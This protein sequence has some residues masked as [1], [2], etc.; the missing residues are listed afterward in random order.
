MS[1]IFH[2]STNTIAR[3][4]IFGAVFVL[5][6]LLFLVAQIHR[7]PWNTD[8]GVAREQPVQFSHEHHVG[9]NGIDCRYCHTSVEDSQLR[10]HPADQDLH[11]LPLARCSP[12]SP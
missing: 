5:T 9:G 11:E 3:A 8:A 12:N 1:Q 4:S 10:R 7:S 6:G 2:R